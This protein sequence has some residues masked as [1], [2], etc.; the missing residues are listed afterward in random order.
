MS[1]AVAILPTEP[2]VD[3]AWQRYAEIAARVGSDPALLADLDHCHELA[4]AWEAWRDLFL[5]WRPK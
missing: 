2:A 1:A 3:A 4:I 5:A